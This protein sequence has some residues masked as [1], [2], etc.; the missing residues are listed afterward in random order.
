MTA[1]LNR[2]QAVAL[3]MKALI[4]HARNGTI[5]E[6]LSVLSNGPPGRQPP[7]AKLALHR[8][9]QTLDSQGQRFV[10]QVI[11]EAVDAALFSTLVLLD[12][13]AGGYPVEGE[14][15]DFALYL[16]T[17]QDWEARKVDSPQ[18]SVRLNPPTTTED[19]HDIFLWMLD[20]A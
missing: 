20:S 6:V 15:S 11:Q 9:F 16:Q 17:Y 5:R 13:A 18:I 1:D 2:D 12:G 4:L 7:E 8:W 10:S 19:L 3:F 14:V